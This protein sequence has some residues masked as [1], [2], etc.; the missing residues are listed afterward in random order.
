MLG[1]P[2]STEIHKLITR[3]RV[4]EHFG[5]DMSAERR[6]R[7]E[8]DIARMV[9]TNEVSPVSINLPAGEQ[10]QSFFVL[11]VTLKE[12]EFDAQNIALLARLFGQRLVMMLEYE[13]W[14]RLALWQGRLYMTEWADA[15]AWTLPL[16]GLNLDQAWEHIVA[17]IAGIDREPGR[18][19]DEQLAQAAQ[20]EKLQKEVARLEK[21]ARAERQP[22]KKF[23]LVQKIKAKQQEMEELSHG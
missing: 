16:T 12:K 14:Q 8:A 21:Q 15:G 7:F 2:A 1:L 10:V 19:L 11:Q 3:K 5:A 6:K 20:R 4:Y 17:Q 13:G 18:A 9:L 22:K 23:E